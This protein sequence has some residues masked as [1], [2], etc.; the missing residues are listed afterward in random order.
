MGLIDY[1]R[2]TADADYVSKIQTFNRFMLEQ[3]ISEG[4]SFPHNPRIVNPASEMNTP[5][6][7][8]AP[9]P[10]PITQLF[11]IDAK[12]IIICGSCGARRDKEGLAHVV[13]ML[14]PKKVS[15]I[16]YQQVNTNSS[17]DQTLS[18]ETPLPSDFASI[19]RN[20]LVRDMSYRATCQTCKLLAT[21][22]SRR[23]I[24]SRDLPPLLAVN[25]CVY[26]EDHLQYWLDGRNGR[27]LSPR[28]SVRPGTETNEPGGIVEGVDDPDAVVYELRVS[29]TPSE[30]DC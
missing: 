3:L 7:F 4:N 30:Y 25:A 10:A 23:V 9:A 17:P 8:I 11:G 13:E 20:A 15:G 24:P 26:S 19:L 1:G 29:D 14:Y 2:E 28:V 18:N 21:Q 27:F 16:V 22:R 5:G 12:S 6:D